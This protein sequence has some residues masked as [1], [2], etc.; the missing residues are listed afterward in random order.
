MVIGDVRV[1]VSVPFDL[2]PSSG[3]G[4]TRF[5]GGEA[6]D[7]VLATA[8]RVLVCMDG[9]DEG[10]RDIFAGGSFAALRRSFAES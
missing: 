1:V 4:D 2:G 9:A 8:W 6:V 10:V 5:T 7:L 3:T